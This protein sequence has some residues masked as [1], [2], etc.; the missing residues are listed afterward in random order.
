MLPIIGLPLYKEVS[1]LNKLHKKAKTS[2][3]KKRIQG[4]IDYI[5]D[6]IRKKE[7]GEEEF[8][9]KMQIR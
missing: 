3:D 7:V 9:E 1:R 6:E 4:Q 2:D 8:F 5:Q